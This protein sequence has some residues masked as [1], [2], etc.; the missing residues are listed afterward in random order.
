[1]AVLQGEMIAW[2]VGE[3]RSLQI[4]EGAFCEYFFDDTPC[5]ALDA[6]YERLGQKG[7]I[8]PLKGVHYLVS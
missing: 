6:F 5:I 1:M 2:I 3:E 4:F 8:G 7:S